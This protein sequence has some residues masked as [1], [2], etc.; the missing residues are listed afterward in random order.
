MK[1]FFVRLNAVAR[2]IFVGAPRIDGFYGMN[3][4]LLRDIGL[5]RISGKGVQLRD[6][7]E[8]LI[9]RKRPAREKAE[10]PLPIPELTKI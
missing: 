3:D 7:P 2:R 1:K 4:H 6:K 8:I 10:T 5:E 9:E